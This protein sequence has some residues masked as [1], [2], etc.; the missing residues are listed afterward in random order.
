MAQCQRYKYGFSRYNGTQFGR[1]LDAF[2]VDGDN[3][4][5]LVI[6]QT[7]FSWDENTDTDDG[8]VIWVSGTQGDFSDLSTQV[9]FWY[10]APDDALYGVWAGDMDGDGV[11]DLNGLEKQNA[12]EG[13]V[14]LISVK[15][16]LV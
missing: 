14:Y 5:E 12:K 2:D 1:K 9:P 4:T 13:A 6:S 16:N 10:D 15:G 11:A 3:A 8:K 7:T